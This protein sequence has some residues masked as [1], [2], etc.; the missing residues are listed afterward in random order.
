MFVTDVD[1]TL[2][3]NEKKVTEKTRKNLQELKNRGILLGIA[4]GRSVEACVHFAKEWGLDQ[5]FSFYVG[6][7]GGSFY[8]VRQKIKKDYFKLSGQLILDIIHAFQDLDVRFLVMDGNNRYVSHSTEISQKQAHQFFENE[9]EVEYETFL[10]GKEFNKLILYVDPIHM[11]DVR[12]RAACFKNQGCV[13]IQTEPHLFEYMDSRINKGIGVQNVCEHF[14]V[15]LENVVAIGDSLNDLEMLQEVGMGVAMKNA[16]DE[17]KGISNIVS[18]YTN[19]EDAL[20]H[21][22]DDF[23]KFKNPQR[24]LFDANLRKKKTKI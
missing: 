19:E 12:R 20:G 7:N 2:L 13:G 24:L 23:V 16:N 3:N 6:M 11:P 4:S 9:I 18:D 1:G 15:H 10:P 21:F 22:I 14:G 8:D 5:D 17:I